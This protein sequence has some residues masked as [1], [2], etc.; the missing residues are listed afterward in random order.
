MLVLCFGMSDDTWYQIW[1]L[2][3]IKFQVSWMN[4]YGT[5]SHV[6]GIICV[7]GIP[8]TWYQVL[9]GVWYLVPRDRCQV[10]DIRS[11]RNTWWDGSWGRDDFLDVQ[12]PVSYLS[13]K[14]THRMQHRGDMIF[15]DLLAFVLFCVRKTTVESL[16]E[17]S[18]WPRSL[19]VCSSTL[20]NNVNNVNNVSPDQFVRSFT[21]WILGTSCMF[22]LGS[23][24][25]L[26]ESV[27]AQK[28]LD[29]CL[30]GLLHT[31]QRSSKYDTKCTPNTPSTYKPDT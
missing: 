3:G 8:S 1:V 5:W 23:M 13:Q 31:S 19:G 22:V 17:S 25:L 16:P 10:S 26:W 14:K 18:P 2:H 6:S 12:P 9:A 30:T 7:T 4:R 15:L 24:G 28:S 20:V 29:T 27:F 11:E 21:M